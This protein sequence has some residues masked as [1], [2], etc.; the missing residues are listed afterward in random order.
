[1]AGLNPAKPKDHTYSLNSIR[2]FIEELHSVGFLEEIH[3]DEM[4][5]GEYMILEKERTGNG[6]FTSKFYRVSAKERFALSFTDDLQICK[7]RLMGFCKADKLGSHRVSNQ[8]VSR[9][10]VYA[11]TYRVSTLT[12]RLI[13]WLT[14]SQTIG[15]CF[16]S[17]RL[18]LRSP[19]P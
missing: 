6:Y 11:H 8:R 16:E 5:D 15:I 18:N 10:K 19:S 9:H 1:M 4:V 12:H 13:T 17:L 14:N 7:E 3:R 2:T